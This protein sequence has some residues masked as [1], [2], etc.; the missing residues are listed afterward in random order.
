MDADLVAQR[1]QL[2]DLSPRL[3]QTILCPDEPGWWTV[4]L[5]LMVEQAEQLR[6]QAFTDEAGVG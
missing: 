3:T 4:I 5:A 6:T 1:T 2:D